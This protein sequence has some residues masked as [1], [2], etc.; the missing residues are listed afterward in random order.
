MYAK[1]ASLAPIFVITVAFLSHSTAPLKEAAEQPYSGE[2]TPVSCPLQNIK[3][4]NICVGSS[5]FPI[6]QTTCPRLCRRLP[7]HQ[8]LSSAHVCHLRG[9][10][11]F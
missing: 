11:P 5:H 6:L 4:L 2:H 8:Y 10:V 7:P 3:V 9:S 1:F